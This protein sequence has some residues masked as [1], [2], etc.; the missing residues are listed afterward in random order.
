MA[1]QIYIPTNVGGFT[2]LMM[3]ILTDVK[4]YLVLVLI[5]ISLIISDVENLL[6]CFLAVCML[7]LKKCLVRSYTHVLIGLVLFC[8]LI[9][10]CMSCLYI[11][12][13]KPLSISS[14]AVLVVFLFKVAFAVQK[15]LNLIRSYLFLFKHY[16]RRWIRKDLTAIYVKVFCLCFPLRIV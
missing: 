8:F 13:N 11:L 5:C 12:E 15:L 14:F 6:M 7:S 2:F 1:V 4:W 3:T 9:L 16:S 10:S